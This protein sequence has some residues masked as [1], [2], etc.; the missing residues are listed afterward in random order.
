MVNAMHKITEY[1][2]AANL[3]PMKKWS[4]RRA[5]SNSGIH[6]GMQRVIKQIK[7]ILILLSGDDYVEMLKGRVFYF[8]FKYNIENSCFLFPFNRCIN[9]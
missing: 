5:S 8:S 3:E 1:I 9:S 4:E 6:G 2:A 7:Q